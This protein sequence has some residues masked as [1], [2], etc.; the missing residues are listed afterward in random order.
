MANAG[1]AR[2]GDALLE[3]ESQLAAFAA[4]LSE[5]RAGSTGRLVL[6]GGEAG[7]GKT[8]M[9]E[10]FCHD[11]GSSSR[12][13]WGACAPLQ[14]PRPLGPLL[15]VAETIGGQ[16]ERAVAAAERPYEVATALLRELRRRA[17]TVLVLEDLH[18]ADEATID[19]LAL[20]GARIATAPA[21]V[22]AS[23]RD[24]ELDRTHRLRVVLG[25]VV[26]TPGRITVDPLSKAAVAELAAPHHVD[27]EE[28]YVRTGGN[29]FFVT[30]V[31]ATDGQTVPA[32]VRDA[33]LARAARL[34]DAARAL[35]DAISVI[36]GGCELWLLDELAS[37]QVEHLAECVASG[38]VAA[39]NAGVAFRHELA[40]LAI[41]ESVPADR[42][43]AL[44]RR[45]LSVLGAGPVSEADA[46]VLA[47]H[48]ELAGDADGVLQW[49]TLA[50]QRAAASGAHRE[51]AAQYARALRHT[52]SM[53][54][55]ERA[56]LLERRA[57]EC[58]LTA[59]LEEAIDAQQEAVDIRRGLRDRIAEGNALRALSRLLFF[60]GRADE[61]EPIAL[62]AVDLLQ[63]GPPGHDLAMAYGN[64]SQR[65][66]VVDE[67]EAALEWGRR[68]LQ[69]AERLGDTEAQV[70][71]LTNMG[72]AQADA[73]IDGGKDLLIRALALARSSGL[74]EHAGRAFNGL[75]MWPIRIRQFND[76][77]SYL[78]DGL[79]FCEQRGLD[80]WRLYLL[81]C[82]ASIEL[83]RGEWDAAADSAELVLR[84][85]RSARVARV[86][87]LTTRGL[88]RAR[89]GDPD[90]SESLAEAHEH[91]GRARELMQISPETAARAELAWLAGANAT[92]KRI[93]EPALALGIER[94]IAWVVGELAYWRWQAGVD[95]QL[96]TAL[97]AEPY[98][99]SMTGDWA[100]AAQL[101]REIGCPYEAALALG[102]ADEEP[103]LRQA[104][105]EL[106]GL[107]ARPATAI[108]AR[109]LRA[110]GVRG[111]PRGPR[112]STQENPAGLTTRELEVLALVAEGLRNAEI[113][114]RLIVTR[115]TVDHHVSAILRK[116]DAPTRGQAA[117][118][119]LRLGLL[120]RAEN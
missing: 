8:A 98:R 26:R 45:A 64:I 80:T 97:L 111:V 31:L 61:G 105:E 65:R 53:P 57:D 88:I 35:L 78:E 91:A 63:R 120:Q 68:A 75:V 103:A 34:T 110:L 5:V 39:V 66:M 10:R 54:T 14:T 101:W 1:P 42:K 55:G 28:L 50:A 89:R 99:L 79:E 85:P 40:R 107:G 102:G 90:A 9:L 46:A 29:P 81:A 106:R 119:A 109:R 15:D 113:A 60:A 96:P 6:V 56:T 47:H 11:I 2:F 37:E 108:V 92:V 112:P 118:A 95:E 27:A 82:R 117:A 67:R 86:W 69:L 59:E 94:G 51:A 77:G 12:L 41:E 114:E 115:K 17:P 71:A 100:A 22:L 84:N 38:I 21:L 83:A 3:R 36:P 19:V 76:V 58:Y 30:E 52:S 25:E 33:V 74:D 7:A 43:R 16:F 93:T 23:Y 116:L 104:L 87:A 18:W 49:A 62:E 72:M 13:M 48:A 73:G 20:V 44:H 24:D 32:T 4:L 70:Y